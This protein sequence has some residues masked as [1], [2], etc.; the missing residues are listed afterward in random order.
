MGDKAL[1]WLPV[2]FWGLGA[3]TEWQLLWGSW[4]LGRSWYTGTRMSQAPLQPLHGPPR[5]PLLGEGFSLSFVPS[6]GWGLGVVPPEVGVM[7]GSLP[8]EG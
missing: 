6:S 8:A 4:W 2:Q 5:P 1:R 3:H 7:G